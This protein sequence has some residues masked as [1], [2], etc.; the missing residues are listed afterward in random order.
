[1]GRQSSVARRQQILAAAAPL[2][3]RHGFHGVSVDD[4]GAA[5]GISGPALYR[6]FRAKEDILAELLLGV[7]RTLLDGGLQR[8]R[9]AAEPGEALDAL[10]AWHVTFALD[11]ADVISVQERELANLPERARREVRSLQSRYVDVWAEVVHAVNG[12]GRPTADAAV[13]AALALMSS[14]PRPAQLPRRE[15]EGLLHA[16][17]VTSLR[18]AAVAPG[19]TA[20]AGRGVR[21]A[22]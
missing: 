10:V 6:H 16:M 3:A 17:A 22:G 12:C 14:T 15:I 13:R 9:R 1:M 19:A 21:R 8:R 5:T 11:N 18:A 2:F 7:S 4:L 20:P